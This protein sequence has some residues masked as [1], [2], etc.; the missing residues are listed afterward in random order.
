MTQLQGSI[1]RLAVAAGTAVSV[2][3]LLLSVWL[4]MPL[5]GA[6]LFWIAEHG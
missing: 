6:L 4:L 5:F 2:V 3:L 1:R